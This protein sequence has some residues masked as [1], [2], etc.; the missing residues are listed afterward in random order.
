MC[1]AQEQQEIKALLE[2]ALTDLEHQEGLIEL[3]LGYASAQRQNILK[4]AFSGQ[5]VPQDPND[6]PASA[7]LERIRSERIAQGRAKRRRAPRSP[8]PKVK[9]A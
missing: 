8:R 4:A 7:L 2:T 5:L 9:V 1:S 3:T 6:E